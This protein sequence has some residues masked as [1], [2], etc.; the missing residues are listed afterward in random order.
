MLT[1]ERKA[2]A[3]FVVIDQF[4]YTF[5]PLLAIAVRG[6]PVRF[7]N[8]D[9]G[10]HNVRVTQAEARVVVV[11]ADMRNNDEI[12]HRFEQTTPTPSADRSS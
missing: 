6:Q 8:S 3:P 12:E 2:P 1:P 7:G 10:D 9:D 11:N 5:H 4:A